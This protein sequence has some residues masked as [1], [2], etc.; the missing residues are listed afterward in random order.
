M[1][2]LFNA[3]FAISGIRQMLEFAAEGKA[4]TA[5]SA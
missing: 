4:G 5:I 2:E 1:W 3:G